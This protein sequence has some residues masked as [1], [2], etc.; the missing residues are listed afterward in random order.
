M[1]LGTGAIAVT[2]ISLDYHVEHG[3]GQPIGWRRTLEARGLSGEPGGDAIYIAS[4]G[5]GQHCKVLDAAG[6]SVEIALDS[7]T[8]T[9][10]RRPEVRGCDHLIDCLAATPHTTDAT[11]ASRAFEAS[12]LEIFSGEG[13]L[14]GAVARAG[15][16][17]SPPWTRSTGTT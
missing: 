17:F 14:S 16:E 7:Q 2:G 4:G 3:P 6:D 8:H 10:V 5:A 9:W 13:H 12:L 1:L 11:E 15:G